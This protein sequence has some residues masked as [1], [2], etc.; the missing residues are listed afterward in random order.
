MDPSGAWDHPLIA[1]SSCTQ[2]ELGTVAPQELLLLF[3][4]REQEPCVLIKSKP[5][6][7]YF[8]DI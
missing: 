8:Y 7:P 4:P 1:S 5:L 3:H 2:S 6:F